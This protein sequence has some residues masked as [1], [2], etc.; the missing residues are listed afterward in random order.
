LAL[1]NQI[2]HA[3]TGGVFDKPTI[4]LVGEGGETE[5]VSPESKLRAIF[6]NSN[7]SENRSVINTFHIYETKNAQDTAEKTLDLLKRNGAA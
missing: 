3:A 5:I 1:T 4:A 6:N 2:P 7:R